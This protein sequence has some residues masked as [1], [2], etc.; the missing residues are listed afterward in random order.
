MLVTTN[1]YDINPSV[2]GK[3]GRLPPLQRES[4]FE[5][6]FSI[7]EDVAEPKST[8][9]P[10]LKPGNRKGKWAYDYSTEVYVYVPK[11]IVDLVENSP[12][13]SLLRRW[14]NVIYCMANKVISG[15]MFRNSNGL[16]RISRIT[17]EGMISRNSLV[18]F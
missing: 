17:F 9:P 4:K 3:I 8:M 2:L 14:K 11:L 15:N 10:Q 18:P 13:D 16:T 5:K 7:M 12:K 1:I 6:G